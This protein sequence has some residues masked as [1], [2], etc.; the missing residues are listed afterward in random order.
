[1]TNF[2]NDAS[3]DAALDQV[4]DNATELHICTG[5]PTDRAAVLVAS[6]ADVA[7]DNTD[8]TNADGDVSG[9]KH[10]VA[11]Q[12]IPS[13]SGSGTPAT[14]CIISAT[15]LLQKHNVAGGQTITAGNPVTVNQ[16]AREVRDPT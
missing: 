8:F 13:A 4:A 7:I 14:A 10:T 1:M 15:L 12:S 11:Q 9:R 6:L 3:M 16:F 5:D 2:V